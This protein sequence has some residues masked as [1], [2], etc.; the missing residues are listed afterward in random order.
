[1]AT[2][3]TFTLAEKTVSDALLGTWRAA[4]EREDWPV[5]ELVKSALDALNL[6]W[7]SIAPHEVR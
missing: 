4:D 1:M 6:P 5:G 7:R 2:T 3:R